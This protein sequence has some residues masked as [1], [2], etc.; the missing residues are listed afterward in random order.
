M[1]DYKL[2]IYLEDVIDYQL[3]IWQWVLNLNVT[4][5]KRFKNPRRID[6]KAGAILKIYGKYL[7]LLDP[8]DSLHNMNVFKAIQYLKG[9]T[10][11]QA[12]QIA[13]YEA[14]KGGVPPTYKKIV[15]PDKKNYLIKTKHRE[16]R[17]DDKPFWLIG[18]I[19]FEQLESEQCF[20][21]Y[22]FWTTDKEGVFRQKTPNFNVY[23]NY[24]NQ[25]C[26]LYGPE[27]RLFLTN[28]KKQDIGGLSKFNNNDL[29]IIVVNLKSYLIL[30][31]L[32]YN[33]RYVPSESALFPADF[34]KLLDTFKRVIFLSD[35][36]VAGFKYGQRLSK[37]YSRLEIISL[38]EGIYTDA[39][40]NLK[41]LSDPY[42]YVFNY[43]LVYFKK[44]LKWKVYTL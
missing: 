38:E 2:T 19:T 5:Y 15:K 22:R 21:V 42:D 11:R 44:L 3:Q 28:F 36:D 37:Q 33:S 35:N 7:I 16:W 43:G 39:F 14:L 27:K 10:Y 25:R 9:V 6:N 18:N 24:L 41:S 34:I 26:K 29:I 30:V 17:D 40:G 31:N 8:A 4:P 20:P 12:L 32:G 1:F 13:Y 23:V